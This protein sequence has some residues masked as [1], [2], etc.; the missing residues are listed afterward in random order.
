MR[1][2]LAGLVL[3]ATTTGALAQ[4]PAPANVRLPPPDAMPADRPHV[5]MAGEHDSAPV[6][7][8]VRVNNLDFGTARN[9]PQFGWDVDARIGTD[10]YRL[11]LKSEGEGLRARTKSAEVQVLFDTPISDF[12]N[13]QAGWR[14]VL[15]P[16]NRNFF[17]IGIEGLA[18]YF[19]DTEATIFVSERGDASLHLKGGIDIP[20]AER[21]FSKPSVELNAYGG[22]DRVL[23]TYAGFGSVKFALQTRY[24]I[25]RQFAP[26]FELGWERLLG[27]TAGMAR[28]A[29]DPVENAYA[30]VGIRMWY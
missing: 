25:T 2:F 27:R 18:Q 15:L 26:Y 29:R 23:G 5:A 19:F 1:S 12:F 22:D 24:E 21:I 7:S 9:G 20:I 16:A 13:F 28:S 6:Y 11:R 8:F 3:L 17:A 10:D 4:A 30:V 14:R